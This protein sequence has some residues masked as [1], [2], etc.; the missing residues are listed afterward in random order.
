MKTTPTYQVKLGTTFWIGACDDADGALEEARIGAQESLRKG[1]VVP[2]L[3]GAGS[4]VRTK[5]SN[6]T[7]TFW[8]IPVGFGEPVPDG[9][10]DGE[11][12]EWEVGFH[13]TVALPAAN[14]AEARL[15]A[16]FILA[17]LRRMDQ[18]RRDAK[19]AG[20]DI[21]IAQADRIDRIAVEGDADDEAIA[22]AIAGFDI[23]RPERV[24]TDSTGRKILFVGAP[25][26][27]HDRVASLILSCDEGLEQQ[28]APGENHV[29]ILKRTIESAPGITFQDECAQA[30]KAFFE[31]TSM[32]ILPFNEEAT[33]I[34]HVEGGSATLRAARRSLR[35]AER[36]AMAEEAAAICAHFGLRHLIDPVTARLRERAEARRAA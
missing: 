12:P 23:S 26:A 5:R 9:G 20:L 18:F 16:P 8:Q 13:A 7:E 21:E 32:K 10:E 2:A 25:D 30:L 4:V 11:A 1:P 36:I 22:T 3:E 35:T 31:A 15:I 29:S 17:H 6:L 14:A 27:L 24:A 33:A 34:V 28:L 19:A